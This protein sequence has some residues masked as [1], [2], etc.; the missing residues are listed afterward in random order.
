MRQ[1]WQQEERVMFV[2]HILHLNGWNVLCEKN[3]RNVDLCTYPS[4]PKKCLKHIFT[5]DW[6]SRGLMASRAVMRAANQ[7]S[8]SFLDLAEMEKRILL[9]LTLL[10][11]LMTVLCEGLWL[12]SELW[13]RGAS[14]NMSLVL[15]ASRNLQYIYNDWGWENT[16]DWI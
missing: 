16:D 10:K 13:G 3:P 15:T 6:F 8:A 7:D 2:L 14:R 9:G 11:H 4:C 1:H 12:L 5:C